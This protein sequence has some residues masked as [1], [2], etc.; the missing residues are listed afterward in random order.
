MGGV[1]ASSLDTSITPRL[2]FVVVLLDYTVELI[3]GLDSSVGVVAVRFE[4]GLAS[5]A[6]T[7]VLQRSV[8]QDTAEA[9]R[10][11]D[12]PTIAGT[13]EQCTLDTTSVLRRLKWLEPKWHRHHCMITCTSCV[14]EAFFTHPPDSHVK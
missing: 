13:I 7:R 14:P 9:T 12:R 4:L 11:R 2:V 8:F 1:T 5:G 6:H 3:N 10:R